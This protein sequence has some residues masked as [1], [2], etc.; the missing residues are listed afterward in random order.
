MKNKATSIGEEGKFVIGWF[1]GA[2]EK[3]FDC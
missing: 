1:A 3:E 2:H